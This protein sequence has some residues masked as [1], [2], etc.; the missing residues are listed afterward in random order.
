MP[1]ESTPNECGKLGIEDLKTGIVTRGILLNIACLKDVPYLEPET[2]I[3]VEDLEAWEQEAASRHRQG[4]HSCADRA[5]GAPGRARSVAEIQQQRWAA[6]IS[7]SV[8]QGAGYR[9]RWQ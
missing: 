4:C 7:A 9:T 2:P 3:Y 8:D 5:V 1:S 6:R